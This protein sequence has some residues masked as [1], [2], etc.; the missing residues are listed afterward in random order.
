VARWR[1]RLSAPARHTLVISID[2]GDVRVGAGDP[3]A[4]LL[5]LLEPGVTRLV[6]CDVARL[7]RP[8]V[9]AVDL[10]ARLRLT[11]R[12]FGCRFVVRGASGDL[13]RLLGLVGLCRVVPCVE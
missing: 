3:C 12:R 8:D 9:A 1:S 7:A 2:D 4:R 13:R 10:V 6:V 11:C 5:G